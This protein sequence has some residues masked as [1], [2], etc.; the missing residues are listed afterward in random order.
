MTILFLI[1]CQIMSKIVKTY[2]LYNKIHILYNIKFKIIVVNKLIIHL[3]IY[4]NENYFWADRNDG[5]LHCFGI[6][7]YIF[8]I[9]IN[10][11]YHILS[12]TIISSNILFC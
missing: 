2:L 3:Y 10:F 7:E 12:I 8:S 11:T 9:I 4:I 1:N 5:I 6:T